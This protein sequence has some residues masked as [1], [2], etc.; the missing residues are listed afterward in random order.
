MDNSLESRLEK[1]LR[2]SVQTVERVSV[3]T[4]YDFG[5]SSKRCSKGYEWVPRIETGS[6]GT[7]SVHRADNKWCERASLLARYG[8]PRNEW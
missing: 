4:E 1:I 6:K 8:S 3:G 7:V 2:P 5:S